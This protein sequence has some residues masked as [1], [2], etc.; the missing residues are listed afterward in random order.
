M[1]HDPH[2]VRAARAAFEDLVDEAPLAPSWER[3]T[4]QIAP[5][6]FQVE[7]SGA[8]N[9]RAGV[10]SAIRSHRRWQGPALATAVLLAILSVG[11]ALVVLIGMWDS[12][13]IAGGVAPEI[14]PN[15]CDLFTA[16]EVAA[17]AMDAYLSAGIPADGVPASFVEETQSASGSCNWLSDSGVPRAWQGSLPAAWVVLDRMQ[18]EQETGGDWC[19]VQA[20]P[21]FES[22]PAIMEGIQLAS[23]ETRPF[24]GIETVVPWQVQIELRI[25]EDA[26]EWWCFNLVTEADRDVAQEIALDIASQM[27]MTIRG[28]P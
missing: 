14:K 10:T 8:T 24:P 7:E 15:V 18:E 5:L 16:D 20:D 2:L 3:V 17:I 26:P 13:Q 19:R 4:G 1:T 12:G 21:K 23:I 22:D 27:I 6:R 9:T 28:T 25:A 11:G